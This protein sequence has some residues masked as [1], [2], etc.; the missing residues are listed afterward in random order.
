MTRGTDGLKMLAFAC[1]GAE[2]V[3]L[4]ASLKAAHSLAKFVEGGGL[5][6]ALSEISLAA[7]VEG[8][9]KARIARDPQGQIRSVVTHLELALEALRRSTSQPIA[10]RL[11]GAR[12]ARLSNQ[13][14]YTTCLLAICYRYLGEVELS[15]RCFE[16]RDVHFDK[17]PTVTGLTRPLTRWES[18]ADGFSLPM[19][20][21]EVARNRVRTGEWFNHFFYDKVR[22][23]IRRM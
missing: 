9:G 21:V 1:E 7:A 6:E 8:L 5:E 22:D 12:H 15:D 17:Y 20:L 19:D 11:A 2:A 10:R 14:D 4:L 18:V 16:Q 3:D 13:F 23:E